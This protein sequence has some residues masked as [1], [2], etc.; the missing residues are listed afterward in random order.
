VTFSD[1]V[2]DANPDEPVSSFGA[3]DEI[4]VRTHIQ[5]FDAAG[6]ATTLHPLVD[7]IIKVTYTPPVGQGA[8][9]KTYSGL[10]WNEA[11]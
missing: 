4:Y 5:E 11:V 10:T 9:L 7:A 6:Q 1:L 8:L 3:G 2:D